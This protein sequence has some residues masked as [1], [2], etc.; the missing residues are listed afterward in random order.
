[1]EPTRSFL[2][3]DPSLRIL[4]AL[5]PA[6]FGGLE[7]V[8]QDLAQAQAQAG[9][10]VSVAAIG[11]AEADVAPFL[12]GL[13]AGEVRPHPVL[14]PPRGYLAERRAVTALCR[15]TGA[16]VLHTHGYRPDVVDGAAARTVGIPAVTSV[17]GFTGGGW[18]NRLYEWLQCRAYRGFQ[19]VVAV[20]NPLRQTL[21]AHGVPG[22]LL[23]VVRNALAEP[24]FFSR[25]A[26]RERL[27][28]PERVFQIAWVG[29]LSP[30]KGPDL[31]LDA[32]VRMAPADGVQVTFMG[33]GPL[34]EALEAEAR[35]RGLSDRVRFPGSVE[36]AAALFPGLD[37]V[38][39][40][41]RTEGTPMVLLEAMAAGTPVV[42]T[43]VGGIPDMLTESEAY[44]VPPEDPGALAEAVTRAMKNPEDSA[45]RAGRARLRFRGEYSLPNWVRAY[46]QVY[47]SA[48]ERME[49]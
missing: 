38:V 34:K 2:I 5:A 22:H 26:A 37:L 30:E 45:A 21:L 7:R 3:R 10:E 32:L 33:T 48:L 42:A 13:R 25:Q 40:S 8:V 35:A 43:R 31:F 11:Q 49:G 19:A 4:H 9:H 47:G 15:S 23:H 44:L 18:R 41:S 6:P 17:H 46:D 27:G 1:M 39:L 28:A 20:S 12:D 14:V 29:R 24:S 36:G 16:E